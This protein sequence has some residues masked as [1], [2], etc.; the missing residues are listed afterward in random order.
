MVAMGGSRELW[1]NGVWA[2][3]VRW[4]MGRRLGDRAGFRCCG[5]ALFCVLWYVFPC[6]ARPL[7]PF[8]TA[9]RYDVVFIPSAAL[10]CN[11]VLYV[12]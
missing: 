7:L 11:E 9:V 6:P 5:L 12:N 8:H 2:F 3:Y 10:E 4:E 1:R